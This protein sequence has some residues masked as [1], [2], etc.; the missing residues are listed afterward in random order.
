MREVERIIDQLRQGFDGEPWHGPSLWDVL[1]DVD[2][3][4]AAARPAPGAHSIWEL[5]LHLTSWIREITRRLEVGIAQ[6]PADGD[7][8]AVPAGADEE[9]WAA[10]LRAL[11]AAHGELLTMLA[12]VG[13]DVLDTRIGDV[14]DRSLGSGVTRYETLHGLAQHHAYHTGQIVLLKKLA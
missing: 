10:T 9:A 1:D 5:V 4:R 7:W 11:A 13:E 2:A 6:D 3:E 12:A 8:P 14:R